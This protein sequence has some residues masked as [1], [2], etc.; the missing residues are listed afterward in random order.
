MRNGLV[1]LLATNRGRGFFR[2]DASSDG[3]A[4]IYLYD[5]IVSDDF[6]GGVSAITFAKELASLA[7][8]QNIHLRINS[9][10]G[11]V[12]A[13][14]AMEQTIREHPANI[15]AHI[16]GYAASAASYVALASDEVVI[17][18]GSMIMIHKAWTIGVGNS[19]D[20]LKTAALLEQV[21]ESLVKTYASETGQDPDRIRAWMRDETWFDSQQSVEYGFA[22][23]IAGSEHAS[24]QAEAANWDLSAY[25][26]APREKTP[27]DRQTG[28]KV[29]AQSML[30]AVHVLTL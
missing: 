7:S 15:I 2:A 5:S 10:G 23:R 27:Q 11:D 6:W 22:D 13:A 18:Q 1:A 16:D 25:C 14:R 28:R 24:A 8:A 26:N 21:D 20:L 9:P 4:T 3:D 19:E 17:G 12:F 29:D 30:R